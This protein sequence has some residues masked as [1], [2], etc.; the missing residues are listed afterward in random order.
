MRTR[1]V[2]CFKVLLNKRIFPILKEHNSFFL[3]NEQFVNQTLKKDCFF[4]KQTIIKNSSL[5]SDKKRF[6]CTNYFTKQRILLKARSVRKRT[7]YRYKV[8]NN[9]QNYLNKF[10]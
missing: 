2:V 7:N 1:H 3:I 9:L 5:I 4:S 6:Y 10:F 8:N